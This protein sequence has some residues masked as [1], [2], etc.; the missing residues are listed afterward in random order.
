MH[1]KNRVLSWKSEAGLVSYE[2]WVMSYE[3]YF[4]FLS[5]CSFRFKD[6]VPLEK[7]VRGIEF[8]DYIQLSG[9]LAR[10]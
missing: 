7:G 8:S 9:V 6:A 1:G 5:F 4:Y 3:V 10:C 2:L